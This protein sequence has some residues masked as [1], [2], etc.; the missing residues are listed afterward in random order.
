ML[1]FKF[2]NV[3]SRE[4]RSNSRYGF[5]SALTQLVHLKLAASARRVFLL[6]WCAWQAVAFGFQADGF[7]VPQM[8]VAAQI[9][10]PTAVRAFFQGPEG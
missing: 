2:A 5:G 1:Y 10:R 9:W 3:G 7:E 6:L 4:I 8:E